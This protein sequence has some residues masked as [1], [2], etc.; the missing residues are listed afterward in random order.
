MKG[1]NFELFKTP[2]GHICIMK[3]ELGLPLEFLS[4]G[5]YGQEKNIKADFLGL[6]YEINGVPHGDLLPLEKKWVITVSSQYGCSM[7]CKFCDVPKVGPG[8]N[9]TIYD[10]LAQVHN[11]LLLHP[12]VKTAKRINLHYARMGEPTRNRNVIQS[13]YFLKETFDKKG[14]GFHP[15][16]STVMPVTNTVDLFSFLQDW[17][18]LKNKFNGEAGLQIS[19]NTTDE[20]IRNITMPC[21]MGLKGIS[22]LMGKIYETP[23]GRKIALNF[24]LTDAPVDAKYLR[25][26]FNP[27]YF[28]CKITPMHNT[29]AVIE[30]KM[31]TDGGYDF[32]YPYKQTEEALKAEGF[33]V[34]VFI[35]SKE[36]DK[37]RIT[38]GNAILAYKD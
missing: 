38:C 28:M 2:T 1:S 37:S 27:Q 13:A 31:M 20:R 16:V 32:Y 3:G 8:R 12:E 22:D 23:L 9:A 30:N 19:I 29:R 6:T 15:V 35:P 33:D 21:A 17:I 26:L 24:A 18:S 25:Q 36:E 7:G 11:A 5:D 34:I 10:L 4:L 14:W